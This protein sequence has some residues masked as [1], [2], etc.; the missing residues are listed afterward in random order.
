[1]SVSNPKHYGTGHSDQLEPVYP[2]DVVKPGSVSATV[3]RSGNSDRRS[4]LVTPT[5]RP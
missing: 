5:R 3:G 4:S 2:I 1:M